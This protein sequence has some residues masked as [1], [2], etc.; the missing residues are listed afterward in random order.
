MPDKW[1]WASN[2]I[3]EQIELVKFWKR[4]VI[5]TKPQMAFIL[6]LLKLRTMGN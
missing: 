1:T 5:L 3:K 6:T 2:Y 4:K